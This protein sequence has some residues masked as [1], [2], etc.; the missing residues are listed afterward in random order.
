[1]VMSPGEQHGV[2]GGLQSLTA[3]LVKQLL[4]E[5]VRLHLT[6]AFRMCADTV[7]HTIYTSQV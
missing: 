1:M 4:E 2:G 3:F 7:N 5:N 6:G